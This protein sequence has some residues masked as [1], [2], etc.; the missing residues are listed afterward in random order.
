MSGQTGSGAIGAVGYALETTQGTYTPPTRWLYPET[1]TLARDF[2]MVN[3]T[4]MSGSRASTRT[5][6]PTLVKPAGAYGYSAFATHG[7]PILKASFGTC[8][9]LAKLAAD[10]VKTSTPI[11]TVNGISMI[12]LTN[13]AA[14]NYTLWSWVVVG[15]GL[16]AE[17]RPILAITGNGAAGTVI[18]VAA[19]I[20]NAAAAPGTAVYQEAQFVFGSGPT[21]T[22]L[23][24]LSLEDQY[25]KLFAYKHAGTLVEKIN[26]KAGPGDVKVQTDLFGTVK[27]VNLNGVTTP[28]PSAGELADLQWPLTIRDTGVAAYGDA[29]AQGAAHA[30]YGGATATSTTAGIQLLIGA[31]TWEMDYSN[32]L[33]KVP[34]MNLSGAYRAFPGEEMVTVKHTYI[35]EALRAAEWDDYIAGI[36]ANPA[37]PWVAFSAINSSLTATEKFYGISHVVPNAQ[38]SKS[39]PVKSAKSVIGES[40]E[41]IGVSNT[42][43]GDLMQTFVMNADTGG[44]AY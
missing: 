34:A 35:N 18:Y 21:L 19:L 14:V 44:S 41:M 8:T 16:T 38:Y 29:S 25:S 32:G 2:D 28:A 22:S 23:P 5:V 4:T 7:A 10:T 13:T 15:S 11:S 1:N 3:L 24:S 43:Q 17:A 12:T 30:T 20:T 31:E 26:V 39:T 6:R 33:L 42:A 9:K 40:I 37:A 27:P 36:A